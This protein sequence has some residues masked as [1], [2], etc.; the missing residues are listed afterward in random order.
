M[1]FKYSN[2]GRA[3]VRSCIKHYM[4]KINYYLAQLDKDKKAVCFYD[5]VIILNILYFFSNN[6][7]YV[8]FG[9]Y[10]GLERL[11][12]NIDAPRLPLDMNQFLLRGV[13]YL[14][15]MMFINFLF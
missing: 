7:N 9:C 10:Y 3:I 4:K 15:N 12:T 14:G 5:A 2:T 13:S 6:D 11:I 8:L 1:D